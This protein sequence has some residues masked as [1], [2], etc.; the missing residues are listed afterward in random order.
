M[1][2]DRYGWGTDLRWNQPNWTVAINLPADPSV[3]AMTSAKANI[4]TKTENFVDYADFYERDDLKGPI[5]VLRAGS[6]G[7]YQDA[8]DRIVMCM[9][10]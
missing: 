1:I 7:G 5:Q 3:H 6:E 2:N 10:T 9:H 4:Y 8:R